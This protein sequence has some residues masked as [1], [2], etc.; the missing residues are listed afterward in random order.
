[1]FSS[2]VYLGVAYILISLL[3]LFWFWGAICTRCRGYDSKGCPS[4]YGRI[5]ALLFPR[6]PSDF[7]KAFKRNIISV[8]LQWFIPLITGIV[9]II[10]DPGILRIALLAAFIV[11]AFIILPF[12]TKGRGCSRC[13]QKGECPWK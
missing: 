4:G 8:A 11:V 13:P 10:L 12:S 5:S 7:R 1:M 6:R 2:S 9:Y 3:G